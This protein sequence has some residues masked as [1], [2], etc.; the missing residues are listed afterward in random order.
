MRQR[1]SGK[2]HISPF[3]SSIVILDLTAK[4]GFYID[5]RQISY[6]SYSPEAAYFICRDHQVA[7]GSGCRARYSY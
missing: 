3:H 5:F 6:K 2:K 4:E 1:E 7:P